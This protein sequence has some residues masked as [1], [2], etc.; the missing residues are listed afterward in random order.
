L[1]KENLTQHF[2]FFDTDFRGRIVTVHRFD[3]EIIIETFVKR[4]RET[5]FYNIKDKNEICK[6]LITAY[7]SG[8]NK[9][10]VDAI[11][12]LIESK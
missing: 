11:I 1:L 10:Y 12:T 9:K 3:G 8:K 5:H 4:D 7:I 2:N 6:D